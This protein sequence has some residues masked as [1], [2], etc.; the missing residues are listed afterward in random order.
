MAVNE[1]QGSKIEAVRSL[2]TSPGLMV[3]VDVNEFLKDTE[4]DDPT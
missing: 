3:T 4:A 1:E 2:M